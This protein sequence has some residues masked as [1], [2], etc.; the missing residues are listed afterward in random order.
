MPGAPTAAERPV[1]PDEIDDFA[2]LYGG[3]CAGCHGT[4]AR[5][6]AAVPLHDPVYL[7]IV[8]DAVLRRTITAGV[9]GTAMPAFAQSAG[10]TL[11]DAQIDIIVR[12]MRAKWARAD[13]LAGVAPPPYAGGGGDA[14]RGMQVYAVFC[15]GCHGTDG[16]GG[17][18][19]GSIVDGSYLALVSDQALRTAVLVG[20]PALGAPDWRNNIPGHPMSSQEI[21]DVVA[22]MAAH[23]P[24]FPGQPYSRVQLMEPRHD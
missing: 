9:P 5:P 22:W 18:H 8:D 23:R 21:D 7:A 19:A 10:G 12:Q 11:T 14:A 24:S 16:S 6:G 17:A 15:S 2:T 20:R 3:N 13:A 1:R 4:E